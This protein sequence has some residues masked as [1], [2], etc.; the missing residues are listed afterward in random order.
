MGK[1][2]RLFVGLLDM[3]LGSSP[4]RPIHGAVLINY[5]NERL[6]AH[7]NNF[8]F[9]TE[10]KLYTQEDIPVPPRPMSTTRGLWPRWRMACCGCW[11]KN[12]L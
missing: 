1:D 2:E 7:F 9:E 4:L 10:A 8:V 12:A 5:A 3:A 11:M 6:Q